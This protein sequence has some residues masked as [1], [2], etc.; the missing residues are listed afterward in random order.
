MGIGQHLLA[1]H[2]MAAFQKVH[3]HPSITL[4]HNT[5]ETR[6]N[7]QTG[8][9]L[10]AFHPGLHPSRREMSLDA[11]ASPRPL[12]L[13]SSVTRVLLN[14]RR[15]ATA[16]APSS[17]PTLHQ[18]I[19]SVSTCRESQCAGDQRA[20]VKHNLL[21]PTQARRCIEALKGKPLIS[22]AQ[23]SIWEQ[24]G[25]VCCMSTQSSLRRMGI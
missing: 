24:P 9:Q 19:F 18:P 13:K 22:I 16:L 15:S 2:Q 3:R 4:S 1:P 10:Q 7:I 17:A 12:P 6:G 8:T 5:Y 14:M 25:C 20:R 11:P 23:P 21:P